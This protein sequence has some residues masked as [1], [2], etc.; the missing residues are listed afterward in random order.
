V[1]KPAFTYFLLKIHRRAIN[2]FNNWLPRLIRIQF[3]PRICISWIKPPAAIRICYCSVLRKYMSETMNDDLTLLR[4]QV[5]L[6]GLKQSLPGRN[7]A[8]NLCRTANPSSCWLLS[9]RIKLARFS[10]SAHD[11]DERR[12]FPVPESLAFLSPFWLRRPLGALTEMMVRCG[13]GVLA[14]GKRL[15]EGACPQRPVSW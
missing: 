15:S 13:A 14:F 11:S 2:V 7:F 4:E 6:A 10:S 8:L 3:F 9:K 12:E 5:N 1:D